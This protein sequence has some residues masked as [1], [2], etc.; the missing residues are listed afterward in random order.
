MVF[1]QM[2]SGTALNRTATACV[3]R[4]SESE[5]G[6]L[7]GTGAD[8]L[9]DPG[10]RLPGA[11]RRQEPA[12]PGSWRLPGSVVRAGLA[13][14]DQAGWGMA[15]RSAGISMGREISAERRVHVFACAVSRTCPLGHGRSP[16]FRL[17]TDRF[18][19]PAPRRR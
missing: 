17:P 1:E 7:N 13:I 16:R 18:D 12:S 11:H 19:V 5:L 6:R 14:D 3:W 9:A 8:A 2:K 15:G 4:L 10:R